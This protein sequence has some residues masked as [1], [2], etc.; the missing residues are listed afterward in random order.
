MFLQTIIKHA[1]SVC[2]AIFSQH[3]PSLLL[4]SLCRR[5]ALELSYLGRLI[6]LVLSR[7]DWGLIVTS[8][9]RRVRCLFGSPAVWFGGKNKKGGLVRGLRIAVSEEEPVVA[10]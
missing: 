6:R 1:L 2:A 10:T 9:V 3:F 4:S 7:L 8:L 5:R